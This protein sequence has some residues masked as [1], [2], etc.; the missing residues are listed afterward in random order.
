MATLCPP[1]PAYALT[2]F[3]LRPG[4]LFGDKLFGLP[5]VVLRLPKDEGGAS[6]SNAGQRLSQ[7]WYI[8]RESA[9]CPKN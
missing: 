9:D 5:V 2:M 6:K 7:V 3:A 4:M 1:V 8:S